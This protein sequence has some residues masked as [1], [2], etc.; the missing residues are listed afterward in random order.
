V[1]AA[2]AALERKGGV[3]QPTAGALSGDWELVY[4]TEADVHLFLQRRVLV[5]AG[6]PPLRMMLMRA[7][8]PAVEHSRDGD[9]ATR[10]QG[11]PVKRVFQ[12]IDLATGRLTNGIMLAGG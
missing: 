3:S 9:G 8:N 5:R 6:A 10:A 7:G 11:L 12:N 1:D 4:T 2:A